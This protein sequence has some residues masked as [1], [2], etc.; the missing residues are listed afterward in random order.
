MG[1]VILLYDIIT[2][3]KIK[4]LYNRSDSNLCLQSLA[5][6]I[7]KYHSEARNGRGRRVK[8]D[9]KMICDETAPF[10]IAYIFCF[11]L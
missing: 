4:I 10:R 11:C 9:F 3:L 8:Q 2:V 7:L 1:R 5:S 6:I